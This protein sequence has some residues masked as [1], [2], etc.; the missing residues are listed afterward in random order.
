MVNK[1]YYANA[2][3][4]QKEIKA[5]NKVL[6]NHLTL[7]DGPLVKEFETKVAKIFGKKYG[8]MVNSGSSAN[9]IALAALDLPKGGEVITPA[10]T[11]ATTV[12]PIYQCGLVPHFVDVVE[13]EFITD[14]QHIA[15]AI[16]KK[17]VAIMVPNLLGNVCD[18]KDIKR[19]ADIHGLKII[20]D[21]ADTIGY[22]YYESKDGTT[23]KYNDLVTTSFYASHIITAAGQGGMVCTNN[24]KL[25]GKL[26]LLRGWGRSSAVF[27]ESEEIEKRFNTKVDGIDYDSKFIFTDIGY[28]FLPSEIS[29][30]FGLEQLK[31]L[32]KYKKIRQ[33]NFEELREFFMP[34][35]DIRWVGRVSW[36]THADT[37]W[38]AYPLVLDDH[39]PFTRKE[40]QIHFEKNGI[41]VRTIFTGN[42]TRQPIMK[43]QIWKGDK[44]FSVADEVMKN[45]MLIGAHQGMSLKE[46]N[47]I[48]KVFT[49][50]VNKYKK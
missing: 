39:A 37:P 30:A 3:Y 41:Q 12:A 45:G 48:K 14:A 42:I 44:Q 32:S 43:N 31:K 2:V 9:L 27:N 35:C 29:A 23:G 33:R 40:M 46:V 25:V 20:E 15:Q 36:G 18:W 34:Y 6:K 8:V 17:T 38:L 50:L 28:N 24:K 19:I 26:K 16:N 7:M 10:L 47:R 1:V 49:L 5:V 22:K 21:C 13:S 11:F 4:D